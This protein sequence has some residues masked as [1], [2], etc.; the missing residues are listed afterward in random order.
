MTRN[1]VQPPH[2]DLRHAVQWLSGQ[3]PLTSELIEEASRRF[4]LSPLDEEFLLTHL[5]PAKPQ[6]TV[7][8]GT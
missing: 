4:D 2:E 3:G 7:K 6:A 5:L 8:P 1:P